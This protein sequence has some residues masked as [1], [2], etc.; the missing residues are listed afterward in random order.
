MQP[1][2]DYYLV[3]PEAW[4][5][6]LSVPPGG[7]AVEEFVFAGDHTAAGVDGAVWTAADGGWWSSADFSRAV[8]ADQGFR[9]LVVAVRRGDAE[10][11]YRR[12]GGGVLPA[13]AMLRGYFGDRLALPGSAPLLLT[14]PEVPDGFREKRRYRILF[15][16]ELGEDQVG[17]LRQVW[18]MAPADARARVL[19]T[20]HLRVAGDAFTWE[21]RRIGPGVALC[22]DVTACL[23]DPPGE[24]VGV[25]LRELMA[26]VRLEGLVPVTIERFA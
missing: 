14:P 21:L 11:A 1:V 10:A 15:A 12:L 18:G 4:D 17:R 23:G 16:G 25:L 19:G 20:A 22:V 9:A 6:D 3:F 7:I 24:A 26:V 2:L 13:E 5:G 8:R